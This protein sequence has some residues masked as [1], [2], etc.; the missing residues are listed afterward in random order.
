MQQ[1][2]IATTA[3]PRITEREF[4]RFQNLIYREAGIFLTPAKQSLL[5]G[6]L[7]KRLRAFNLTAFEDYYRIVEANEA[8]RTQMLNCICTNETHFFREK[9]HFD[10]L[11]NRVLPLWKGLARDSRRL[12]SIRVWSAGCSTGEEPYS[13]AM[14]LL[15]HF[16]G[17]DWKIEILASDISTQVLAKAKTATWPIKRAAEIPEHFLKKYMLR[18]IGENVELMKAGPELRSLVS[19]HQ[20]NLN[21]DGYAM[22]GTFDLILCCN[23]LIYFNAESRKN[24]LCRL[25][26]YLA[27]GGYLMLGHAESLNGIAD[28]LCPVAP[29]IYTSPLNAT[30]TDGSHA[31]TG[32]ARKSFEDKERES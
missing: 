17:E 2:E 3:L 8:E 32:L 28:I 25:A 1:I 30:P 9:Q 23:V 26:R 19:F 16:P 10:F 5:V 11:E 15:G 24:V 6:R 29:T 7:A 20:I 14:Y 21:A 22:R 18:G 4:V 27:P 12:R 31:Q 13:L